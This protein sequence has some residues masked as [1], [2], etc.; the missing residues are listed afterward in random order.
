M[1]GT[2]ERIYLCYSVDPIEMTHVEIDKRR[3][4][5]NSHHAQG[6]VNSLVEA[7]DSISCALE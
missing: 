1:I 7:L 4:D 3:E 6:S 2:G 5:S